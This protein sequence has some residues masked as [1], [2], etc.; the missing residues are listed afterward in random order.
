MRSK[1]ASSC[2]DKLDRSSHSYVSL[3]STSLS[4]IYV[5]VLQRKVLFSACQ[6]TLQDA[7]LIRLIFKILFGGGGPGHGR[8]VQPRFEHTCSGNE[9]ICF[10]ASSGRVRDV[11]LCG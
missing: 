9:I 10:S 8:K 5:L 2:I 6:R 7:L 4:G 3:K 1:N 11:Y